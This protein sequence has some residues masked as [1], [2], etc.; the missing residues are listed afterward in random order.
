[1]P[2]R[3]QRRFRHHARRMR[4]PLVK[5]FRQQVEAS[6][7]TVAPALAV[8]GHHIY[9]RCILKCARRARSIRP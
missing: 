4:G 7:F 6:A 9:R 2:R 5:Y 1:M 3:N 8:Y